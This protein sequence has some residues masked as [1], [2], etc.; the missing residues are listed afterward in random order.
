MNIDPL[1]V[2]C[3]YV[4]VYVLVFL[5][6]P[7]KYLDYDITKKVGLLIHLFSLLNVVRLNRRLFIRY[8]RLK[9]VR[10]VWVMICTYD[11]SISLIIIDLVDLGS[12]NIGYHLLF[13]SA[14]CLT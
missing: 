14:T 13:K 6:T 8:A 12:G 5:C 9:T 10:L 3:Y 7:L 11:Y 4:L 2:S 1:L